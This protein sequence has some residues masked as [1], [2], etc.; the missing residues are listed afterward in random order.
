[1]MLE[2]KREA[3]GEAATS[4]P[5]VGYCRGEGGLHVSCI[6]LPAAANFYRAMHAHGM[7]FR[8]LAHPPT[9]RRHGPSV[10][11]GR[12]CGSPCSCP[13]SHSC[14]HR[15]IQLRAG[16]CGARPSCCCGCC[17]G[18]TSASCSCVYRWD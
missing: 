11:R 14:C 12:R 6:L 7:Q 13:S 1:M 4:I 8:V 17:E 15:L 3:E 9:Y 5:V 16:V 2:R 10:R 18:V